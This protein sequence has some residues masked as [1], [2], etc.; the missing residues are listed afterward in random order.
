MCQGFYRAPAPVLEA[1]RSDLFLLCDHE[2]EWLTGCVYKSLKR[3]GRGPK[4]ECRSPAPPHGARVL[5]TS[6]KGNGPWMV[7]AFER[8]E[9]RARRKCIILRSELGAARPSVLSKRLGRI[10]KDL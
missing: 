1:V 10:C 4:P 2:P 7:L 5:S 9:T 3:R 8:P 6:L